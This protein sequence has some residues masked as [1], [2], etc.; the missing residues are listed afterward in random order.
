M[1]DD[2]TPDNPPYTFKQFRDLGF[3]WLLNTTALHPRG[4][5]IAFHWAAGADPE[6]NEPIGWSIMGDGSEPW[7]FVDAPG[8]PEHRTIDAMFAQTRF[9][10]S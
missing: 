9:I 8:T 3:L 5:A 4:Y 1:T 10:L 7:T 6:V 2:E